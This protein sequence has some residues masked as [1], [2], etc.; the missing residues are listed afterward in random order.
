MIIV[1]GDSNYR[2]ICEAH[3]EQLEAETGETLVFRQAT[4]NESLKIALEEEE[5][6]GAKPKVIMVGANLNEIATRAKGNKGRDE[7]V[8]TV[9]MEQNSA[10][11]NWAQDHQESL[12]LLA[13]PFLRTDPHWMEERL[14][15][16]HFCMKD[17]I[18]IYSPFNVQ[19][20]STTD[21]I[22]ADLKPDKVHLLDS[23]MAKV[24]QTMISDFK[25]GL[26][27]VE[28]LRVERMES[29]AAE[30]IFLESSQ[31]ADLPSRTPIT[32]KKRPRQEDM[33]DTNLKQGKKTKAGNDRA[34]VIMDKID[35]LVKSI[36]EERDR[37]LEKLK[38]VN[39]QQTLIISNQ[40]EQEEKVEK[41]TDLV[42]SD[43][44]LF[45][46]MKEDIDSGENEMMKD[47]VV[48]KRM[49]TDLEIPKDKKVLA[50]FVQTE[51]RKLVTN[52]LGNDN[53]VKFVATLYNNNNITQKNKP[54]YKGNKDGNQV[55]D[56]APTIPPFK[57]V[58]KT[59]DQGI[60]FREKAVA[61]AKEE[62]SE[63]GKIYFTHMQNSSTRI[64]TMLLWGVVDVIKKEKKEAWVNLSLNKPNIQVKEGGKIVKTL[65]FA[66]A[67][68]EYGERIDAK[69]I[70]D[71]TK[72]ARWNFGGK[73]ER[74]FIV[75]K[76]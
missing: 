13:P 63:L 67:M 62:G 76:D 28:K 35:I 65:T 38:V 4:T 8:K 74:L 60:M 11:N 34:D 71:T 26:R 47:S 52:I 30:G 7:M 58:F 64:R 22:A 59:K 1:I 12:I 51:G 17:D 44:I 29:D 43:S 27:D 70:A 24:A 66:G 50:K 21:I 72:A 25:V 48:V 68:E 46:T 19:F 61:K 73:L 10:V 6:N 32:N 20:C 5:E 56:E 14:K 75:L 37:T 3:K 49:K 55:E 33:M 23:G 41:L 18:K 36:A 31:L 57:I 53:S 2:T 45:A 15:W 39:E 16:V 9:V 69:V 42:E 54:K 40:K